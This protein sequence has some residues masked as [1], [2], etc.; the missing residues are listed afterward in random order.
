MDEL[1]EIYDENNNDLN[2]QEKRSIIHE[3]GLFHREVCIFVL[4][5]NNEL[6]IQKR[7]ATK[8]TNLIFGD[9]VQVILMLVK[10]K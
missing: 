5:N 3:K 2:Y 6:L 8:K 10:L 1:L 7:S 4:N 9:Y